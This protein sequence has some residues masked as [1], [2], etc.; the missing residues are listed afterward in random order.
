MP[1]LPEVETIARGLDSSV[2]GE[3]I[4]S[5]EIFRSDPIIQGDL[6]WFIESL[7]DRKILGVRRRAKYLLFKLHPFGGLIG[8]LR[9]TGKFSLSLQKG[10]PGLYERVRFHLKSGRVL[11][12]SDLRCFGTLEYVDSL[13]AW[14]NSKVLGCEPFSDG[15]DA[16]WLKK[17]FSI[18]RREIK[19][20]LLDQQLVCGI[21]NIYASEILFRSRIHPG[22]KTKRVKLR[23]CKIL[24][25]QTRSIL[26][27]AIKKNGTSISNFRRIDEKSGE[28]QNFL[29]VYRHKEKPCRDCGTPIQ[30][31]VQQQR[32]TF[33]CPGCQK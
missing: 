8:H 21:G 2:R 28:F 24:V 5:L 31:L 30:R 19:P 17:R 32:S 26:E 15:F 7:E 22:R 16:K 9:M 25:E 3:I 29:R 6:K 27:E 33:Y 13:E 18:S 11:S 23:E 12:F 20:A 4:E 1:E 10:D 14:E